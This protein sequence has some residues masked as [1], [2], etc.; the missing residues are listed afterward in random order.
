MDADAEDLIAHLCGG[1]APADRDAFRHIAETALASSPQCWGP[2]S[3]YRTAVAIWRAYFHPPREDRGTAWTSAKKPSKLIT[4]P[5]TD[6]RAR[7]AFGS[8]GE[9]G[10]LAISTRFGRFKGV[11]S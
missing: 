10:L 1:L 7:R 8:C 6:R 2:G 3:I 4:E 11:Y 5:P 9:H